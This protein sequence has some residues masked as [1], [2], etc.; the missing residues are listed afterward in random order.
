MALPHLIWDPFMP[1]AR[2]FG[3]APLQRESKLQKKKKNTLKR[4]INLEGQTHGSCPL[5]AKQCETQQG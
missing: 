2:P 5:V 3:Y 1:L 4:K